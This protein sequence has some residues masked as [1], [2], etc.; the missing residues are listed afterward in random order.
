MPTN[1][2]VEVTTA[3]TYSQQRIYSIPKSVVFFFLPSKS[4]KS[5]KVVKCVSCVSLLSRDFTLLKILSLFSFFFSFSTFSLFLFVPFFIFYYLSAFTLL[6]L[7]IPLSY[8][9]FLSLSIHIYIYIYPLAQF[10]YPFS[11]QIQDEGI[12]FFLAFSLLTHTNDK[13]LLN[14]HLSIIR[15]TLLS[16]RITKHFV[17]TFLT[18]RHHVT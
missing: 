2:R 10:Y 18:Q 7:S 17:R 12:C 1:S 13:I 6:L 9:L 5:R 3:V 8:S 16:S 14:K 11:N 4:R 15:A